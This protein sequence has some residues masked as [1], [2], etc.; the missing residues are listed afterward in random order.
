MG[1]LD[2]ADRELTAALGMAMPLEY[3]GV[4]GTLSALR[5]A[6]GRTGEALTVAEDAVARCATMGGCGMFRGAFVRLVHAEALH[7]IGAH[8]AAHHAIAGARTR[9]LAIADR[10]ADRQY[11]TSFLESVPENART[12]GLADAWLGAGDERD[13][14]IDSSD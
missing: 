5:L 4:L 10:I 8:D 11:R 7:A 14:H 9:L 1:D 12:L 3:P 2:A 6:Q 13:A